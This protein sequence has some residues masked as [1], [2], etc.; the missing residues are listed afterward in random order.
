[1]TKQSE[2]DQW[3]I[4]WIA[5]ERAKGK[6]CFDVKKVV[7]SYYVYYQTTRYNPEKKKREKVSA[8]I[9]KLVQG[10]GI[11]EPHGNSEEKDT[12]SP[13]RYGLGIDTGGTYTDAVIVDLDDYS[14]ISKKKS[15][16]T[17]YDLS[18]GLYNSVDAVLSSVDVDPSEI[19]LIG[20]STTL[21]TNSVLEGK[22][23]DVGLI[24]I[25]WDPMDPVTFGE[26]KQIFVKG[27]YDA[28]GRA[29]NSLSLEEV[30]AAIEEVSK[31]VDAIAIS[32]LFAN[33]NA[34]Q[35]RKVKDLAIKLTG[36]PT[37]SGHELSAALGVGLRAQTA[38]LNGKLIPVVTRFFSDVENTFHKKGIN[39]PIMVYKG[40][41]SVM[42]LDEA[43]IYPVETILSGPAASSMGGRILSGEN[44]CVVVDIG[45]TS[46]DVA[47][48]EEGFPQ[49]QLEGAEVGNWKT[50]VK[51]V[52]MYTVALGGDSRISV[53]NSNF[54]FGP[55][56]V[57]P[58]ST[59]SQRY[60]EIIE[61]IMLTDV[62]DYYS[63]NDVHDDTSLNDRETRVMNAMRDKG[64]MS[65]MDIMN[66][67]DGLWVI[68]DELK[69]LKDKGMISLSSLTPTD[70]MVFLGMFDN[71][72]KDGARAGVHAIAE[73]FGMTENQAASSVMEEIRIKV[74]ETVISKLLNDSM[75]N[76]CSKETAMF[77]R[78]M[79]SIDKNRTFAMRSDVRVPIV[80]IGAPA[81]YMMADIGD[82][83]GTDVIFPDNFEVGNAIGAIS[84]R[85]VESLSA[86]ITPTHDFRYKVD[87]PYIGP[88]YYAH[89]ESAI[90]SARSSLERYLEA[91]VKKSGGR[92]IVTSSKIKTFMATEGG[93][94]NWDDEESMARTI[95][96]IE[97]NS[98]AVGDPPE[99]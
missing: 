74:T 81:R 97:V 13:V 5:S 92:N 45:G 2:Y 62:Y 83:L 76:W 78:R 21:A 91:E 22:G 65:T 82:R 33:L 7:N 11:V 17:H 39:A 25:G 1:M 61:R 70:I 57:T 67:T 32:G 26:K 73:K 98:R 3:V 47:V 93:V 59:F 31:D 54:R 94:G 95:N 35:E 69:S 64:P 80:G 43:K 9:G 20:I 53:E 75:P 38:V 29:V 41:G 4:D 14:V 51:A 27:G 30:T 37:V 58:L 6:K 79:S 85:I 84:S 99:V 44:N 49:I 72:N 88:S 89:I 60:P 12:V 66:A 68:D 56:R 24:F 90:S 50:R 86:I 77:V 63:V 71:G 46:T 52:D 34:T 48:I 96:Y 87:I 15:L 16:T 42:T 18:V 19:S 36:L 28:K 55:E 10:I 8:Y 23:G 40:D